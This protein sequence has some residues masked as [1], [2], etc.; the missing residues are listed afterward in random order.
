MMLSEMRP[1]RIEYNIALHLITLFVAAMVCHGELANDRPAPR[2]LTEFFL[3]MS[4]GGVLGGFFNGLVAPVLFNSIIEYQLAMVAACLLLPPL[5]W[6]RDFGKWGLYA[7]AGLAVIFTVFGLGLIVLRWQDR[8]FSFNDAMLASTASWSAVAVVL[9]LGFG[10]FRLWRDRR[11]RIASCFDLVLPFAL[12]VLVLGLMWGLRSDMVAPPF[13]RLAK[14]VEIEPLRLRALVTFALPAVLCY[15]FVE[16]STRFG[17]GLG[18]ILLAGAIGSLSDTSVQY[19]TRSF[20]GVLRVEFDFPFVRLLHGTTLHGIQRMQ[21]FPEDEM[22]RDVPLAYYSQTGPVGHLFDAYN[23][24][25]LRVIGAAA[26]PAATL[27]RRPGVRPNMGVIGLGTGTMACYAERGQHLTFFDIDPAVRDISFNKEGYFTYVQDARDRHVVVENL[28]LG[29]ARLTMQRQQLAEDDKYGILVVDAFSSDAI[30]IHLINQQALRVFRD[31][32]SANGIIAYH[33]SNRHLDLLPVLANIAE[34]ENMVGLYVQDPEDR[35]I[36]KT[37][38]TW[39]L[40]AATA[41]DLERL[42]E[43]DWARRTGVR[44]WDQVQRGLHAAG[45]AVPKL[46]SF[47][48]DLRERREPKVGV[49]TDDYSNLLSV[50]RW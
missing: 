10:L 35:E 43:E 36:Y 26:G 1:E 21:V 18:A 40:L 27:V 32:V 42:D 31:K 4:V 44:H 33:I 15:T 24:S 50:F 7:D 12:M 16:R 22:D 19:Q 29:D 23:P 13:D 41:E 45:F 30:P 17:L 34:A 38:T 5:G 20:F 39:V 14:G 46:D 25:N 28:V 9:A 48:H 2:S 49:W 37:A 6:D 11:R 47:W 8:Y 3:W